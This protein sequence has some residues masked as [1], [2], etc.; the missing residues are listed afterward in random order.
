MHTGRSHGA[1]GGPGF[2]GVG[3]LWLVV[4]LSSCLEGIEWCLG[5]FCEPGLRHAAGRRFVR[6]RRSGDGAT[7]DDSQDGG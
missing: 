3:L 2:A 5:S 1:S 6:V 4:G 7:Q